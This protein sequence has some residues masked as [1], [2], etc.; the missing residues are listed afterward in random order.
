MKCD[1]CGE[2]V[3]K[4][5]GKLLVLNSGKKLYFCSGKCQKNHDK[6]RQHTYPE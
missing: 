2:Q 4:G 3:Q 6:G 1:Y 5:N